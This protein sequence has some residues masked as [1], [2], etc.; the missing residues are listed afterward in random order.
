M[1]GFDDGAERTRVLDGRVVGEIHSNLSAAVDTTQAQPLGDNLGRSFMGDTKGGAFDIDASKA[2]ELLRLPNP[3]GRPNSDVVVP[4]VNG[5]DVTRRFR[6]CWIVDF[7]SA[8]GEREAAPYEGPFEHLRA[9]LKATREQSR[10]T[11]AEWWLH[12]RPRPAMRE[13]L[14][15]LPR[16]LATP[17]VAK[18]RLFV[19]MSAPTLPDH[20]LIVIACADDHLFGVLHSRIHEVWALRQGTALEDRPRYTPTTTFETFPLPDPSGAQRTAI[21][22]AAA[23]LNALRE[24]WLNPPEWTRDDVLTFPGSIDGPWARFVR[25]PNPEGVGTVHYTRRVSTD[26]KAAAELKRRTLTKL[27]N[28][29]PAWLDN[30]H[31]AL[32]EAVAAAYGFP[33]DLSDDEIL[34][35]R[36]ALNLEPGHVGADVEAS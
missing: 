2:A 13:A 12:E 9:N 24:R 30:A 7:G 26:D 6:D 36:L 16:F 27:Y 5:L 15:P 19:W 10:T 14:H 18:H 32:D 8:R 11:R 29:R 23:E 35:R 20:Q 4:W 28:A 31:H 17:T 21:A 34:A 25:D 22:Q 33:V 3:S 1:L